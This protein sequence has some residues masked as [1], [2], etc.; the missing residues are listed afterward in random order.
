MKNN[1]IMLKINYST[2]LITYKK[3]NKYNFRIQMENNQNITE[4]NMIIN[5]NK[6]GKN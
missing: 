5:E 6:K 3:T 1:K 4:N 2:N